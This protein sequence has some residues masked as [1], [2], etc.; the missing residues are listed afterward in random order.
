MFRFDETD[1]KILLID[2]GEDDRHPEDYLTL[3]ERWVARLSQGQPFGVIFMRG[4]HHHPH[5]DEDENEHR[6]YE[7]EIT[8]II[9]DFRRDYHDQTSRLNTG[10]AQVVPA[11]WRTRYFSEDGAWQQMQENVDRYA[12]YNWGIPGATFMDLQ[13]AKDW[14]YSLSAQMQPAP[15][16]QRQ[17]Q[18]TTRVGLFY[19]SSTGMT[20]YVADQIAEAWANA[21]QTPLAPINIGEANDLSQFL[22]FDYLILGIP[23]WNI[24][25]LQ[26]DWDILF[27]QLDT[28]DFT[29]KQVAIFG[30]G[31]QYGYPD[32]FLDAVG[33]LGHK[34]RERGAVLRGYWYDEHYE[35]SDSLGFEDG[36][37]MGLGIDETQQAELTPQRI[38]QWITQ[39]IQEFDIS[40][41]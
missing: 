10:F 23:T 25:E 16:P 18:Q 21:G 40:A 6:R 3:R 32:N 38:N 14:L 17:T 30:V 20:E 31:D 36:Q 1:P 12:R 15:Q 41:T 13:E 5:D 2:T 19:G 7:S 27:P 26:D 11:E 39:I 9:N 4:D 37:F 35:F 28:L 33:I 34:L 24:G 8:R 29:G 22:Q